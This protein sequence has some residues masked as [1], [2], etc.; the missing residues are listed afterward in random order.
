MVTIYIDDGVL[1]FFVHSGALRA[2]PLVIRQSIK[3]SKNKEKNTF[4]LLG[5][6]D[7]LTFEL[8]C[9]FVYTG[10]FF[11]SEPVLAAVTR[12]AKTSTSGTTIWPYSGILMAQNYP[13]SLVQQFPPFSCGDIEPGVSC[14]ETLPNIYLD[15]VFNEVLLIHARLYQLALK[16]GWA[17]LCAAALQRPTIALACSTRPEERIYSAVELLHSV[18]NGGT[19]NVDSLHHLLPVYVAWKVSTP[20]PDPGFQRF[21]QGWT[22]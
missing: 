14:A 1:P 10:D 7:E 22:G 4:V 5:W 9:E 2:F 17:S 15:E 6:M 18:F 20:Q 3:A 12:Y 16:S 8:C 21:L 19:E 13:S 11:V